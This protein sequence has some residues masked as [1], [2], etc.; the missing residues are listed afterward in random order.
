MN[1]KN[2]NKQTIQ[3]NPRGFFSTSADNGQMATESLE[4]RLASPEAVEKY[5][6]AAHRF[7]PIAA[8]HPTD[9]M[10]PL[11]STAAQNWL[12]AERAKIAEWDSI[13]SGRSLADSSN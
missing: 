11:V 3:E 1:P 12:S 8:I 5:A 7:S 13:K 10:N 6:S 4:R 9:L 2:N